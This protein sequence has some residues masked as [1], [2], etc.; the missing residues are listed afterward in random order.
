MTR[1]LRYWPKSAM[2]GVPISVAIVSPS[3]TYPTVRARICTGTSEAATSADTP[4]YAP[5]G[6]PVK[7]RSTT[8]LKKP[9]AKA[10]ARLPTAKMAM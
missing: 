7:K 5:C 8:K 10:L 2:A 6:K 3:I 4:K 1:Q 9:G